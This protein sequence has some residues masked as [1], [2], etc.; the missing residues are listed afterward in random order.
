MTEQLWHRVIGD[1]FYGLSSVMFAEKFIL[2][3]EPTTVAT[4]SKFTYKVAFELVF[5]PQKYD[6]H[7]HLLVAGTGF[8]LL[9][10]GFR[11]DS[12]T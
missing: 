5:K 2:P 8:N 6:S 9:K 4:H 11:K 7:T 10:K 3:V 1:D 12:H